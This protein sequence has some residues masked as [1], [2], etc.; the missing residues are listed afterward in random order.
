MK[1][2]TS[3]S[4][5]PRFLVSLGN[6]IRNRRELLKLTQEEF[7]EVT[8]FDRTYISLIERGKR[9]LSILNLQV[10]ASSLQLKLSDLLREAEGADKSKR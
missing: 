9:N 6:V 10:I 4:S 5:E 2:K 3:V 1:R 8:G 7:A